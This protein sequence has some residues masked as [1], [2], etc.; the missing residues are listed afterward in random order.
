VIAATVSA[1]TGQGFT[2]TLARVWPRGESDSW[3]S[4]KIQVS[5]SAA[6]HEE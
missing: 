2:V 4:G 6:P 3:G 1:V 5:W